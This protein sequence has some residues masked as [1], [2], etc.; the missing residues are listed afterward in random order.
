MPASNVEIDQLKRIINKTFSKYGVTEEDT[1]LLFTTLRDEVG[2]KSSNDS[3]KTT[4]RMLAT[5]YEHPN[6]IKVALTSAT[7]L[8]RFVVLCHLLLVIANFIAFF[9]IPYYWYQNLISIYV[10]V[11]LCTFIVWLICSPIPCILT[12][13]E[14]S[15]RN[16]VG[17]PPLNGGF[18]KHYVIN[19]IKTLIDKMTKNN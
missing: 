19:T 13:W 17:L 18:V 14:L 10:A 6:K 16:F 7:L 1:I 15:L 9:I 2:E 4:M 8:W 12:R 11:P 3:F 5:V